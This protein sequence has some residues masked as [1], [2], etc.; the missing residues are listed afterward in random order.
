MISAVQVAGSAFGVIGGAV[1]TNSFGWQ[2][3]Y[4]IALPCIVALTVLIFLV[5]RESPN[6][7]PGVK[8]DYVGAAW[9]G[10]SLTTIVL[11][12]SEGTSWGWT[13]IP[14]VGLLMGGLLA[15]GPLALYERRLAEPV[16]DL[17][18]LRQRNLMVANLLIVSFGLSA[19][20]PDSGVCHGVPRPSGLGISITEIGFY[21][22]PLVVII[23]PVIF[24]AW[25]L[26][27][28]NMA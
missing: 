9:L 23:L 14:T 5:V 19:E 2:G 12:L 10:T 20:F 11:G 21:L 17:K 6:L 3:N 7:K 4:H 15:I 1:I 16:L 26:R 8:L 28:P 22:L 24:W 13:S 25:A 27:F 18:A